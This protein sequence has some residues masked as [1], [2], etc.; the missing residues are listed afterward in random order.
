MVAGDYIPQSHHSYPILPERVSNADGIAGA[1]DV[2]AKDRT[3]LHEQLV[4]GNQTRADVDDVDIVNHA[5]GAGDGLEILALGNHCALDTG[6]VIVGDSADEHMRSHDGDT[7]TANAMVFL[8]FP[9]PIHVV[10]GFI[11]TFATMIDFTPLVRS[12]F[13]ARMQEH[14]RFIDH[15]DAVQQGE[16]VRLIEKA[17]LTRIGRKYDF[18]SIRTP[19]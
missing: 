13:L 4:V 5:L 12:H 11:T 7:Q 8:I 10:S 3:A 18:S 2:A 14:A 6:V 15:A 17:A 16:L 19:G 9:C 1:I